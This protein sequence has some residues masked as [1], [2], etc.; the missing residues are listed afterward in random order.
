MATST[1]SQKPN[2]MAQKVLTGKKTISTATPGQ[3]DE[4]ARDRAAGAEQQHMP[5]PPED[6][7]QLGLSGGDGGQHR[8]GQAA[9]HRQHQHIKAEKDQH[10]AAG[11]LPAWSSTAKRK[12]QT[13]NTSP[14]NRVRIS[15]PRGRAAFQRDLMVLHRPVHPGGRVVAEAA[16]AAVCHHSRPRP[17]SSPVRMPARR[18]KGKFSKMTPR[19]TPSA[20]GKIRMQTRKVGGDQ[21][22]EVPAQHL[23]KAGQALFLGLVWGPRPGRAGRKWHR[24]SSFFAS[25]PSRHS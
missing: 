5:C 9:A 7:A 14:P 18:V 2:S 19:D 8:H 17:A 25:P 13:K 6:G 15:A 4:A 10:R 21:L 12:A 20:A 1:G 22:A 11:V 16:Q 23:G 24:T 3:D